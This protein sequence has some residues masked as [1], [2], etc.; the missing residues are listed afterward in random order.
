MGM[1][2]ISKSGKIEGKITCIMPCILIEKA[3]SSNAWR[4]SVNVDAASRLKLFLN[5][6][7]A[8]F[9]QDD[10]CEFI[11][12][13][14]DN[15]CPTIEEILR[16]L[17]DSKKYKVMSEKSLIPN[18][19]N[20]TNEKLGIAGWYIQQAI[21]LAAYKIVKTK[22]YMVFDSDV[23]CIKKS[24]YKDFLV[25]NL[26][27]LN[28]ETK[29]DFTRIYNSDFVERECAIKRARYSA[30]SMLLGYQQNL[31]LLDHFLGETPVILDADN[32]E[33]LLNRL[34]SF[35]N[36]NWC[37]VL[38]DNA[39]WTEYGL[40]FAFLTAENLLKETHS[41]VSCN[42]ILDFERSIW[43]S[44]SAYKVP[45]KYDYQHFFNNAEL[46]FGYFIV[47]Q[48]WLGVEDWLPNHYKSKQNFYDEMSF[49]MA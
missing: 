44:N 6:F 21:K 8:N 19:K 41:L 25:N 38:A 10:L 15:E 48:S 28:V 45:R 23:I 3:A 4:E 42:Y 49:W 7:L 20:F 9:N 37:D 35:Q 47:I 16:S 30:S 33:A 11:I 5:S 2:K 39:G 22:H 46:E 31:E 27:A 32:V 29:D 13:C 36:R 26:P 12:L 43:H 14:P 17:T 40:Y 1:N 18:I 24:S 34:E